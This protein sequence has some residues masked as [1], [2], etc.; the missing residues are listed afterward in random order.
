MAES[1]EGDTIHHALGLNWKGDGGDGI[2]DSDA[3]ML[4]LCAAALQWRWLYIPGRSALGNDHKGREQEIGFNCAGAGT[5]MGRGAT[6]NTR[7]HRVD[8]M[9]KDPG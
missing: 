3:R 8:E 2:S 9:R 5:D 7:R 4:D 6:R 1:L